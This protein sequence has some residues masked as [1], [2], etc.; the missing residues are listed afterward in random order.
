MGQETLVEYSTSSRY[1]TQSF[2]LRY[3]CRTTTKT[4]LSCFDTSENLLALLCNI[5]EKL[6]ASQYG[7]FVVHCLIWCT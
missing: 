3:S 2:E 6:V 1:Y 5:T 7:D 4:T